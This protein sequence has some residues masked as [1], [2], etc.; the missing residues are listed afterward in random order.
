MRLPRFFR[1]NKIV[2]GWGIAFALFC[3]FHWLQPEPPHWKKSPQSPYEGELWYLSEIVSAEAG[4]Q[5]CT[6]IVPTFACRVTVIAKDETGLEVLRIRRYRKR[7]Y[8][9][10]EDFDQPLPKPGPIVRRQC[11]S[12]NGLFLKNTAVEG[13][14]LLLMRD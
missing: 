6:I 11:L 5:G 13:V 10:D 3:L 7:P 2:S 9:A 14:L 4:T 1:E 12:L 8:C